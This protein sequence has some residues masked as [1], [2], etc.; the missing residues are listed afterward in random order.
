MTYELPNAAGALLLD[1]QVY[2]HTAVKGDR[3]PNLHPHVRDFL[4]RLPAER[5]ERYAGRCPEVVLVSDRLWALDAQREAEALEPLSAEEA[6]EALRG[7]R[8]TLRRVREPGD[9]AHATSQ[10]PC[11]TCDALLTAFG[12]EVAG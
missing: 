9:P 1:G 4:A 10:Q 7:A 3:E 5:R 2:A 11:R 12:I 6:R 8:L